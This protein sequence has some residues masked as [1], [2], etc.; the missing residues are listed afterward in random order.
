M[1]LYT[2]AWK[3]MTIKVEKYM[4]QEKAI[5]QKFTLCKGWRTKGWEKCKWIKNQ[6]WMHYGKGLIDLVP[7]PT[8]L[9]G[10][11]IK[12]IRSWA[13]KITL[14]HISMVQIDIFVYRWVGHL[15]DHEP[16]K[17][18]LLR[19]FTPRTHT[20]THIFYNPW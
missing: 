2:R 17:L 10:L 8:I 11:G 20:H 6:H 7:S 19:F 12:S 4:N 16:K 3:P 18:W 13:Q 9:D 15:L 1:P 5:S 14:G